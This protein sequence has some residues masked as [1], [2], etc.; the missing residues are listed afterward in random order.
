MAFLFLIAALCLVL[1]HR[2]GVFHPLLER[3]TQEMFDDTVLRLGEDL[4]WEER[5]TRLDRRLPAR[6]KQPSLQ[7][8][9]G[10]R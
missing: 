2:L 9:T 5:M 1:L 10:Q 8:K 3:R 6:H 4:E 7:F